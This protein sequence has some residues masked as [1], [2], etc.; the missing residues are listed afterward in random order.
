[1]LNITPVNPIEK[2]L[3]REIVSSSDYNTNLQEISKIITKFFE[4]NF[5]LIIS[6][7]SHINYFY[8]CQD[9]ADQSVSI[10]QSRVAGFI[11]SDWCCSL[12]N[13]GKIKYISDL[14]NKKNQRLSSHFEGINIKSLLGVATNFK[15]QNN[16]IILLGKKETHQWNQQ[17]KKQL[18]DLSDIVAI[19]CHLNQLNTISDEEKNENKYHVFSFGDIPQ[20]LEYNPLLRLWWDSTRKQLERQ[21]EWNRKVIYNMITIMSDQ[22]RNPLA[23]IKM[24]ITVLKTKGLSSEDLMKRLGM[25][26][27]AWRKLNDINEKILQLKHFKPNELDSHPTSINLKEF[28]D[29]IVS[30]YQSKWQEDNKKALNLQTNYE[31]SDQELI[32]IDIQHLKN[33]IVELLTNAGKFSVPNSTVNL[34][35]SRENN[36]NHPQI[37]I[38]VSNISDYISQENINDF[39]QPF[40]REQIVIDTAIPG[41]GVGLYIVQDLVK[42][43]QSTITVDCLPTENPKHCKIVF[44]LVLPQS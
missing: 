28:I 40:Y 30:D 8:H 34:E 33:I 35:I 6:D 24:G 21:I 44:R 29:N 42:L 31:V 11:G 39:F 16:G 26:E 37:V 22:T 5:C 15:G 36:T 32:V 41:I 3:L 20:L 38:I 10:S 9:F 17:E 2:S 23:I 4:V 7:F 1:M 25:L 13:D 14:N 27:E 19:A 18:K 12:R 43:L